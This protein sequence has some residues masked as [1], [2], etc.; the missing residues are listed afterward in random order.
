MKLACCLRDTPH[1]RLEVALRLPHIV[2]GLH[3]VPGAGSSIECDGQS[4]VHV[5][6]DTGRAVEQARECNARNAETLGR[7]GY[8]DPREPLAQN[9]AGMGGGYASAYSSPSVIILIVN[10]HDIRAFKL[11]GEP[12]VFV[13]PDSPVTRK[14]TL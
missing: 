9:F 7:I 11:E 12:P 14:I 13:H 2:I 8:T 4:E 6:T 3:R 10:Q 1:L 5:G